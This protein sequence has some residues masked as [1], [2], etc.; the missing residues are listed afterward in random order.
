MQL[1]VA[2]I[3]NLVLAA[4]AAA[5]VAG[6]RSFPLAFAAGDRHRRRA[7]RARP[8][9]PGTPGVPQSLPFVVIVVWMIFRGQALPLRDY[10]LQRLPAV[11]TG[12]VRP[13]SWPSLLVVTGVVI[14]LVPL[15]WQDAF[16][17][18][19]A[20]GLVLLSVVV[21][22][23]YAGQLSLAQFALAGFGALVA[24]RLVDAGG[25]PFG[26]ALLA[27]R[28]RPPCRS[29]RCSRSPRCAPAA[30]TWRSSRSGS[31]PRS[32]CWSSTTA[33]SSAAS[34]AR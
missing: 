18:T 29:A 24:G 5:L 33:A 34:R 6:F 4:M 20:I 9:R 26:L 30:S 25:W 16:V 12:R 31:A 27:R 28:R 10:F 2:T 7:D 3:T 13:A 8:L 22:T 21:I 15:A 1:Q 17:T 14:L 23:G 11:G 19:F 32:S